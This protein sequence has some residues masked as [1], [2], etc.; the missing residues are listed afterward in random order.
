MRAISITP[1]T[2]VPIVVMIEFA[3]GALLEVGG[4]VPSAIDGLG[5]VLGAL[6]EVGGDV[7][8]TIDGLLLVLGAI[9][10]VGGDVPSTIDGSLNWE[11]VPGAKQWINNNTKSNCLPLV[12][13]SII[14]YHMYLESIDG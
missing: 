6:L 9:L 14:S 4:D 10:E 13:G 12:D 7:P 11:S 8:S 5:L 1:S 2:D 3:L